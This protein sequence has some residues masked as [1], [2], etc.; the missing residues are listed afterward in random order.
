MTQMSFCT[1][2]GGSGI[3]EVWLEDFRWFRSRS[4]GCVDEIFIKV[5]AALNFAQIE[6]FLGHQMSGQEREPEQ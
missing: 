4:N 6:V 2:L 3:W 5:V 1:C